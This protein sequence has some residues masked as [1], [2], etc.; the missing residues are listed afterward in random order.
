VP[1]PKP[2]KTR[3]A[4]QWTDARYHSFVMSALRRAQWPPKYASIAR[5]YVRDGV[6][7]KTGKPCKLHRCPQCSQLYPKGQMQADHINPVVPLSGFD[8]W[9]GVISRLYCEAD[10]FQ[11]ICKSCHKI[12]SK[13]ENKQRKENR[14]KH[15][16]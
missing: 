10:N 13:Q 2:Q 8:S 1:R 14:I 3:N 4:G 16:P 12:K 11:P 7:P 15:G 9:D 5:A 6:N